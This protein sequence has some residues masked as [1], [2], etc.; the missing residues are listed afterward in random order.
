MYRHFGR[1]WLR[2]VTSFRLV[3]LWVRPEG[4]SVTDNIL[5]VTLNFIYYPYP[6]PPPHTYTSGHFTACLYVFALPT[7]WNCRGV[8]EVLSLH[9]PYAASIQPNNIWIWP[10]SS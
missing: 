10:V 2:A 1:G 3:A 6:C 4:E 7:R 5:S 9:P 8:D